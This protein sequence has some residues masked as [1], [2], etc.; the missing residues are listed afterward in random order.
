M[1]QHGNQGKC[2][3]IDCEEPTPAEFCEADWKRLP[4]WV[5]DSIVK[6]KSKAVNHGH[7]QLGLE[8]AKSVEWAVGYL[9]REDCLG[10][11]AKGKPFVLREHM[12]FLGKLK[13]AF[14]GE[15]SL[16]DCKVRVVPDAP[17]EP[18]IHEGIIHISSKERLR[19]LLVDATGGDA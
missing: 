6:A 4:R 15:G 18:V 16:E 1:D 5:K 8:W 9:L 3:R 19:Q 17:Y 2:H 7:M 10:A 12:G 14:T 13:A 11:I